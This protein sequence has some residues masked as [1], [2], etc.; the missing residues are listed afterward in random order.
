MAPPTTQKPNQT[1][2]TQVTQTQ[3]QTQTQT[4]DCGH[5]HH[6]ILDIDIESGHMPYIWHMAME[7]NSIYYIGVMAR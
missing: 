1:P 4:P 2:N 7:Y 3:T 6:W 5:G